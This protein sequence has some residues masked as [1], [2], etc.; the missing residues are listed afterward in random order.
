[1]GKKVITH[2]ITYLTLNH[3]T[4]WEPTLNEPSLKFHSGLEPGGS[5]RFLEKLE[6]KI[7]T[8]FLLLK[9][10]FWVNITRLYLIGSTPTLP[11]HFKLFSNRSG[12]QLCVML[13]SRLWSLGA[14]DSIKELNQPAV[15]FIFRKFHSGIEPLFLTDFPHKTLLFS[16]LGCFWRRLCLICISPRLSPLFSSFYLIAFFIVPIFALRDVTL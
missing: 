5:T 11:F 7:W 9:Q 10:G 15:M 16:L 8:F 4:T 3:N 6:L 13:R 2:L 1:M 14:P 12:I